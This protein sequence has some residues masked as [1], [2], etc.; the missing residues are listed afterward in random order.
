[1]PCEGAGLEW[2]YSGGLGMFNDAR[3]SVVS[4]ENQDL[5][6]LYAD[7]L[8]LGRRDTGKTPWAGGNQKM[9]YQS[10]WFFCENARYRRLVNFPGR[11]GKPPTLYAVIIRFIHH[12]WPQHNP[13]QVWYN[14]S[15]T[16]KRY[17]DHSHHASCH[18]WTESVEFKFWNI[19]II[20]KYIRFG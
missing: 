6:H 7:K 16:T 18:V 3:T 13:Q 17:V 19:S 12:L 14:K 8:G 10:S 20:L 11:F 5:Q 4:F 1:M 15:Q 9:L 2:R